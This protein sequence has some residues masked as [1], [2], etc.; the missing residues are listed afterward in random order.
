MRE[1]AS[2]THRGV[3]LGLRDL[4]EPDLAEIVHY[5]LGGVADLAFLGVD[6]GKLANEKSLR[7]RFAATIPTGDK[8]QRHLGFAITCD[9]T[10]IGYTNVNQYAP[11]TN[12]SHWH[13]TVPPQRAAGVS[14]AL[15]PHRIKT[16]FD[17]TDMARL[18][19]QTRTRNVGVNRML[20]KFVP[21]AE[22]AHVEKP[23]GLALPGEFHMRHVR[24]ED[25]PR[26]FARAAQ[27]R[28]R[29]DPSPALE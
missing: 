5:W 3:R 17:T 23:D 29:R 24:R 2:I 15:Y 11:E 1:H 28:E 13:I 10:F 12:Y 27:L 9:G 20:D 25:L 16:Y 19:H 18:I 8:G 7:E 21:I 6:L 26:I 4:T 22:T 14:S